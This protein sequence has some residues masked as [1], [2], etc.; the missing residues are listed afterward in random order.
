MKIQ[1]LVPYFSYLEERILPE[2]ETEAQELVLGQNQYE[3][4]DG[5]LHHVEKDKTQSYSPCG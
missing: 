3:I 1:L 5:I 4:V 2:D